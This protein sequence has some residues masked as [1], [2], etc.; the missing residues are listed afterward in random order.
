MPTR[1]SEMEK[2]ADVA[3]LRIAAVDV[4]VGCRL[5]ENPVRGS[6]APRKKRFFVIFRAL[7]DHRPRNFGGAY[8]AA[9]FSHSLFPQAALSPC[10]FPP[11]RVVMFIARCD[12]SFVIAMLALEV[13]RAG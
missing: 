5:C 8:V 4:A 3:K 2:E 10:V 1:S 13:Q 11:D 6:V 12:V 7:R 9:N